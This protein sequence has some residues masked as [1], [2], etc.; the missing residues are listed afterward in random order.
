MSIEGH[1]RF[2]LDG[3]NQPRSNS[4]GRTDAD[5]VFQH[6][7]TG[8]QVRMEVKNM[9][10]ASQRANLRE[11][12]S[13]ILKMAEDA[14]STGEMQVW[15]NR[16]DV[17]PEVRRILRTAW[18][19]GGSSTTDGKH[20]LAVRGPQFSGLRERSAQGV[21]QSG[22]INRRGRLSES[23]HGNL[24][25]LPGHGSPRKRHCELRRY[26]WRLATNRRAWIDSVGRRWFR[27]S[28]PG[29]AACQA[30]TEAGQGVP[31]CL[32][33]RSGVA[34]WGSRAPSSQKASSWGNTSVAI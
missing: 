3:L 5:I 31:A 34:A 13:Q 27:E 29:N 17:L 24:H 19:Q 25:G 4:A 12:Q 14:R 26:P 18:S 20:K 9:T 10:P 11:I 28:L 32:C 7:S 2:K 15:A 33:S 16:Q 30:D 6:Q 21:A 8:L 23:R 1:G 22:W